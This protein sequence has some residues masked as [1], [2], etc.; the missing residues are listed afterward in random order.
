MELVCAPESYDESKLTAVF[1]AGS[2]EMGKAVD[3]Q[4]DIVNEFS[5]REVMFLNPRRTDW[6]SSW[7]QT[8]DNDNFRE[9]VEW[10][11]D[12]L[13][14]C[15]IMFLYFDPETKSPI[16]LLELGI[17]AYSS[18]IIIVCCPDGFYRKGNVEIVCDR[19]DL[20]CFNTLSEAKN[21]LNTMLNGE[22]LNTPE[23]GEW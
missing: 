9:Q 18:K 7:V 22:K 8:I 12:G 10:E 6:D 20:M 4:T 14:R 3:W 13:E 5:D 23:F 1:L 11:L 17:H 16:S 21:V 19:Y 2:I 15:D